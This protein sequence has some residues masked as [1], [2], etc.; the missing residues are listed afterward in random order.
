VLQIDPP[1]RLRLLDTRD[2]LTLVSAPACAANIE[3][4]LGRWPPEALSQAAL[5]FMSWRSST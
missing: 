5:Q 2:Q 3:G 4:N 1:R